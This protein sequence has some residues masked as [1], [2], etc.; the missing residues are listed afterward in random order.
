MLI[1]V[2]AEAGKMVGLGVREVMHPGMLC[3]LDNLS[4]IP[5]T[6]IEKPDVVACA[7]NPSAPT[8]RKES[9]Q[10]DCLVACWPD[11]VEYATWKHNQERS[12]LTCPGKVFS[13]CT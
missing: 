3:K 1:L 11:S 8:A 4:S 7:S 10:E 12:D 5:E 6:N 2:E 9:G 13:D